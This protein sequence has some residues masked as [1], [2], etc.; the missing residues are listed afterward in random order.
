M[1]WRTLSS[2]NRIS[3][4]CQIL[5]ERTFA[6]TQK[7]EYMCSSIIASGTA[8]PRITANTLKNTYKSSDIEN[9]EEE[10][11]TD[12]NYL[13]TG[14]PKADGLVGCNLADQRSLGVKTPFLSRT[15]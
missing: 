10:K 12:K 6:Q 11:T 7:V 4:V 14:E 13:S 3:N 2:V 15:R 8:P 1:K 9:I 5:M